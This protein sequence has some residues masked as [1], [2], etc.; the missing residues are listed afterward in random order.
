MSV[1]NSFCR[2]D[3][4]KTVQLWKDSTSEEEFADGFFKCD[5]T[6]EI[7][8]PERIAYHLMSWELLEDFG[9]WYR[10]R[11]FEPSEDWEHFC[12]AWKDLGLME[13]AEFQFIPVN[14]LT[15]DEGE[16]ELL[17]GAL[18]PESLQKVVGHL[19]AID[20]EELDAFIGRHKLRTRLPFSEKIEALK[21]ELHPDKGLVIFAG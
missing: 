10:G 6:E 19:E 11:D 3:W 18:S 1:E 9:D 7:V 2:C 4:K 14:E 8:F 20:P 15:D 17:F 21:R 5:S 12:A 16:S 13:S